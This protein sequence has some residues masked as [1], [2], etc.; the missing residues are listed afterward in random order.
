[1]LSPAADCSEGGAK[2]HAKHKS[3]RDVLEDDACDNA[4]RHTKAQAVALRHRGWSGLMATLLSQVLNRR[5]DSPI[6]R[7]MPRS[8][9]LTTRARV[10]APTTR[11]ATGFSQADIKSPQL[12]GGP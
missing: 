10:T 8:L 7:K 3:Q 12:Q 6:R 1:M 5:L 11:F 2:R 9:Y 4:E